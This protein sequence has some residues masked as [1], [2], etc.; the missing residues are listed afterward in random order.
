MGSTIPCRMPML[1]IHGNYFTP[2]AMPGSWSTPP[3]AP[4]GTTDSPSWKRRRVSFRGQFS[5]TVRFPGPPQVELDPFTGYGSG[6]AAP[7]RDAQPSC[8]QP[9]TWFRYSGG[10][11]TTKGLPTDYDFTGDS[12]TNVFLLFLRSRLYR[13]HIGPDAVGGQTDHL[14]RLSP[15]AGSSRQSL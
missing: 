2:T 3:S 15:S 8:G 9:A 13:H 1:L 12:S 6:W 7:Y 5:G 4:S 11:V 14:R 10:L